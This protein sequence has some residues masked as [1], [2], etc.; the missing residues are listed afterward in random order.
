[1]KI[2]KS[3]NSNLELQN[4]ILEYQSGIILKD[5]EKS[6]KKLLKNKKIKI[7]CEFL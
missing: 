2:I 7:K 4:E 5:E 3:V 6:I 1:M